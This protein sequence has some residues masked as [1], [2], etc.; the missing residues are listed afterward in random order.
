MTSARFSCQA[1]S[2]A[3]GRALRAIRRT[4]GGEAHRHALARLP[5]LGGE[6]K[7]SRQALASGAPRLVLDEHRH[8]GRE[9][10]HRN[11]GV[12]GDPPPSRGLAARE[13]HD[14]GSPAL[15]HRHLDRIE[16]D[17]PEITA[18]PLRT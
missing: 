6:G 18:Q 13:Q 10:G 7:A 1:S 2:E 12:G 11:A 3:T 4:R 14:I 16:A 9:A 5:K 17:A 15:A 8:V